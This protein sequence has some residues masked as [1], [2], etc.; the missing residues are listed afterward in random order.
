MLR[1]LPALRAQP[2]VEVIAFSHEPGTEIVCESV[3]TPLAEIL[4]RLPPGW[5][6]DVVLIWMPENYGLPPGFETCPYPMVACVGDWNLGYQGLEESAL[7]FDYILTDRRGVEVFQRA[8]FD[9]VAHVK[10]YGF[11][12]ALHRR[13][14]D[15]AKTYDVGFV[16]NLNPEVQRERT[17][18]LARLAGLSER[19]RVSLQT[20]LYGEDYARAVN[21]AKIT[22]D[23]SIRGEM[24]MRAYEAPACG[25][26]LFLEEEN[27]EVRDVFQDRVH[28]VLYN[29]DN[30]E[31]LLDHYL[32]HDEE[33]Q[34]IVEAAYDR[35]QD[36]SYERQMSRLVETV[37]HLEVPPE[38]VAKRRFFDLS[39]ADRHRA[40]FAQMLQS[41]APGSVAEAHRHLNQALALEPEDPSVLNTLGVLLALEASDPAQ[42][43]ANRAQLGLQQLEK[44]SRRGPENV[45]AHA[46]R[47]Q[48][49]RMLGDLDGA[50]AA[51]EAALRA[52][53]DCP[54]SVFRHACQFPFA[55]DLLRLQTLEL[56][57]AFAGD[58]QG[59]AGAMRELYRWYLWNALG[60]V[61]QRQGAWRPALGSYQ[62]AL[63]AGDF[64]STRHSLAQTL[65]QL[66]RAEEAIAELQIAVSREPFQFEARADLAMLLLGAERHGECRALCAESL[67]L[68]AVC[69]PFENQAPRL[70]RLLQ[71][72][73][74]ADALLA[75]G[76]EA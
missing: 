3:G 5:E 8:G 55:F 37:R 61:Y 74:A 68:I 23:Y 47:G 69:P 60:D 2:D 58:D 51:F 27:R 15:V 39:P 4:D 6:P 14:P 64:A 33:R 1:S 70:S 62:A 75:T 71:R 66:G 24:N 9:R 53:D 16:G 28:C 26:L 50:I 67:R 54:P 41:I 65:T 35:V 42:Q 22:F 46:N 56:S 59:F 52:L 76:I 38:A 13:L 48:L 31:E 63:A 43:D 57:T 32:T 20:G 49:R 44:A 72:A 12:P 73:E 11:E 19:Y 34:Q 21:Q 29:E 40:C 17:P 36:Y 7:A 30:L 45:V 10:L 18:L 25:S